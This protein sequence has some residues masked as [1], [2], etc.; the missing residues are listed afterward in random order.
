MKKEGTFEIICAFFVLLSAVIIDT[1]IIIIMVLSAALFGFGL[2]KK[3]LNYIY[4]N[5]N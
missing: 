1:S 3:I 4:I 2:S 5:D